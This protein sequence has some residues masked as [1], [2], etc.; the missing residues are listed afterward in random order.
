M[1]QNDPFIHFTI[2]Q[3]LMFVLLNILSVYKQMA[4][5]YPTSKSSHLNL[6]TVPESIFNSFSKGHYAEKR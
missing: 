5:H 2:N 3:K 1:L 4:K 6:D